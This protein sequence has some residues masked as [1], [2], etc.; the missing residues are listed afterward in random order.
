MIINPNSVRRR[1]A[2]AGKPP[3]AARAEASQLS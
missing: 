2:G 1:A 3:V